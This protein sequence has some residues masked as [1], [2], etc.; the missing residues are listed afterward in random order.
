MSEWLKLASQSLDL[1]ANTKLISESPVTTQLLN[2]IFKMIFPILHIR[3]LKLR[4]RQATGW[5]HII[6]MTLQMRKLRLTE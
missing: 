5:V 3:K 2:L 1:K 6:V 4:E